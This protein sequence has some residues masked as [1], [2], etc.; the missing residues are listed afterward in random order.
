MLLLSHV[1]DFSTQSPFNS[2]FLSY[3]QIGV[4]STQLEYRSCSPM[5]SF[6]NSPSPLTLQTGS[7]MREHMMLNHSENRSGHV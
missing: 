5:P 6:L 4:S 3:W 1:T 7:S 2:L